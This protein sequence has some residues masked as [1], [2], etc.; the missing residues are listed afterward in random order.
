MVGLVT[1]WM[2]RQ[3]PPLFGTTPIVALADD[4]GRPRE[5]ATL[6]ADRPCN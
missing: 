4:P 3:R 2:I 5:R 6:S 1:L